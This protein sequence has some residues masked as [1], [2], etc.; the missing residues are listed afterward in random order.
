MLTVSTT[1]LARSPL[2]F[3]MAV[4]ERGLL[5]SLHWACL[6]KDT[7]PCLSNIAVRSS[8]LAKGTPLLRSNRFSLQCP[9]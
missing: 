9:Q 5:I 6:M 8:R 7:P 1:S 4:E 3:S 2:P